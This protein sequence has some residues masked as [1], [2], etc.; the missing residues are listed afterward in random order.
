MW[1]HGGKVRMQGES[2]AVTQAYLAHH[3]AKNRKE[4]ESQESTATLS[5][6]YP[7]LAALWIE[8]KTGLSRETFDMAE[9]VWLCGTFH[10]P[11][12]CPTV[13]MA[14][15]VRMDGTPV[16]GTFSSDA[17]FHANRLA[18]RLFGFRVIFTANALLPGMYHLRAH[19]LDERGL[20][21]FDTREVVLVIRGQTRDHG[22]V[23]LQHEWTRGHEP[24]G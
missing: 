5:A 18:P 1:I 15:I 8:D 7:S 24:P 23:R 2:F 19:T 9:D 21:M 10:S 14:G 17:D 4:V 13:L 11:E 20:R 3:E 6:S 12:D 22:F 16:F